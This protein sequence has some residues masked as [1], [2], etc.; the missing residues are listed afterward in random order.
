[1]A[2]KKFIR[3]Q[4]TIQNSLQEHVP[5]SPPKGGVGFNILFFY[6]FIFFRFLVSDYFNTYYSPILPSPPP[7]AMQ[8]L[9]KNYM[10]PVLSFYLPTS[11]S[12][13]YLAFFF[14]GFS[15]TLT[16]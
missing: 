4:E 9:S 7:S 16:G 5:P 8:Y 14:L 12:A 13:S 6:F 15:F 2:V 10:L 3:L 1:M 11:S